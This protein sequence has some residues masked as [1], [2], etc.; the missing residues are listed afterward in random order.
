MIADAR[1]GRHHPYAEAL[2]REYRRGR[3][4]VLKRLSDEVW[5]RKNEHHLLSQTTGKSVATEWDEC[6]WFLDLMKRVEQ[7]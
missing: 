1:P 7:G 6:D 3:S 4:D 5:Q 2:G